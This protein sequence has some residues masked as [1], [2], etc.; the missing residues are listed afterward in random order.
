MCFFACNAGRRLAVVLC[1]ILLLYSG[2]DAVSAAKDPNDRT[3][4]STEAGAEEVGRIHGVVI[5]GTALL[6]GIILG[7]VVFFWKRS[8]RIDGYLEKLKRERIERTEN[9]DENNEKPH[10]VD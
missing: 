10:S 6:M 7:N 5:L 8:E 9:N 1:M 4:S 3:D 2:M